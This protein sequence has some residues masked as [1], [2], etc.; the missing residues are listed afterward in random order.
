M[1]YER[2]QS[3]ILDIHDEDGVQECKVKTL[4]DILEENGD[5][6]KLI[7]YLKI[8]VEGTEMNCFKHWIK[9]KSM[10]NVQQLGIEMHANMPYI[11]KSYHRQIFRNA[12]YFV[13][14]LMSEFGLF[15]VDYN[16]N[17]YMGKTGDLMKKHYTHHDLLFVKTK[18]N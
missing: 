3:G 2:P 1:V 10:K 6:D 18:E 5:T 11:D 13:K 14:K 4:P 7:T 17:L 15:L 8:D 9:T 16:A 12:I